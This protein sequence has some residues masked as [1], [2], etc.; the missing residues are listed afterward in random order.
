[1]PD[2]DREFAAEIDEAVSPALEDWW[3]GVLAVER[4]FEPDPPEVIGR[5]QL[6]GLH[7]PEAE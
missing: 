3:H 1:M 4:A 5:M 2:F 7:Y 6:N